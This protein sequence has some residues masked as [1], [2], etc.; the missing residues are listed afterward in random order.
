VLS[1]NF[2][3]APKIAD[4]IAAEPGQETWPYGVQQIYEFP[5]RWFIRKEQSDFGWD[6]GPA[7]A[8]AG[9]WQP[10]YVIQ[11]GSEEVHV[12]NT[13]IDIYRQG[14]LP[15]LPPDQTQPWVVNASLDYFGQLPAGASLSYTLKDI[16]NNTV[17]SG[18]MSN[19]NC[20]NETVTGETTIADGMVDLWWP[21]QM[22]SQNLYYMTI[23]L[24]SASNSTVASVTKRLGFRTIVLNETPISQVQLAQGIAPGNN[25]HF[26]INGHEFYAKGSNFI[27]VSSLGN[28]L[29]D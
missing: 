27:P 10:A 9:P 17:T 6:W 5:N 7:F 21:N 25:W 20:T 13:L 28:S 24:V 11:L 19:V 12:R 15:L 1:I 18:A 29:H 14:Q 2:G 4:A 23:D 16:N 26:E 22:G 3:S 8:P